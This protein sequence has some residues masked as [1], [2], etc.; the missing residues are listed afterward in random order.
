MNIV[1][2]LNK[3]KRTAERNMNACGSMRIKEFRNL[4]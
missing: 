1:I 2:K 3:I 4:M